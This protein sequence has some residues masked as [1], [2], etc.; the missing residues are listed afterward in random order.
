M[1][2]HTQSLQFAAKPD[3]PDA[4]FARKLQ[5]LVGGAYGELTLAMQY[6]FQGWNCR[7][8]GKYKD[9]LLDTATEKLGQV[10]MVTT[11]VTRLLK[12]APGTT[13]ADAVRTPA[14]AAVLG[15]LDLQQI[16]VAGGGA[17][18]ADGNGVPWSG[19]YVKASGNLLA[20]FRA[21]AAAEGQSR[22]QTA[23]LYT[24]TADTGVR[25]MLRVMLARATAHQKQWL[26]AIAELEADRLEGPIVP[27]AL[28]DEENQDH[29]NAIWHLSDG[30]DGSQAAWTFRGTEI[31]YRTDPRPLG[32]PGTAP[33]PDPALYVTHT[34]ATGVEPGDGDVETFFDGEVWKNKVVGNTRASGSAG[35]KADAVTAGRQLAIKRATAHFIH[36]KDGEVGER[37]TYPRARS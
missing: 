33:A 1:F 28:L 14:M 23:R 19:D 31:E 30:V 11:M 29:N 15:G 34:N 17:L 37:R 27:D 2:R 6:L 22:L 9:L 36:T 13:A 21:D 4:V 25:A 26:A 3:K 5:E 16:V 12:N 32:G 18:P 7:V 8:E 35:T 10:E 20:D 24:M